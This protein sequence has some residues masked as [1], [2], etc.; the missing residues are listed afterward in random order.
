MA[1][2]LLFR[3]MALLSWTCYWLMEGV[4]SRSL[5]TTK[6]KFS[7]CYKLWYFQHDS[8]TTLGSICQSLLCLSLEGQNLLLER[9]REC[10][11]NEGRFA[12]NSSVK[13]YLTGE[14]PCMLKLEAGETSPWETPNS[15]WHREGKLSQSVAFL[16]WNMLLF[17]LFCFALFCLVPYFSDWPA[18]IW[19]NSHM[20]TD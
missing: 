8:C 4:P 13:S 20:A 17:I 3:D 5:I 12:S 15:T 2:Q 1:S 6:Q 18:K 14:S 19:N 9:V 11:P 7:K 16:L 10:C